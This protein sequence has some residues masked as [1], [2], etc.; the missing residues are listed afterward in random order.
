MHILEHMGLTISRA[1]CLQV[2]CRTAIWMGGRADWRQN[3][4]SS[5]ALWRPVV[6]D[7]LRV[8]QLVEQLMEAH[9][10]YSSFAT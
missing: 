9:G 6:S 8:I 2:A 5:P 7:Q 1:V 3:V 4:S 10:S